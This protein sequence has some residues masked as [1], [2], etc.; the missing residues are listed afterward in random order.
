MAFGQGFAFGVKGGLSVGF[1]KWGIDGQGSQRDPLMAY[2][3]IAYI[4]S[5]PEDNA[6]AV[7]AQGGYHVRGGAVR[8]RTRTVR[9]IAGNLRDLPGRSDRYEFRNVSLA[10]GGKQKKDFGN[11][12]SKVYY[13][14]GLRGDY[15]INTNLFIYETFNNSF[16]PYYPVDGFVQ[17]F[18]YGVIVGGGFEFPIT[19][20]IGMLVEVSINPDFSKQ[21]RQ[22]PIPNVTNPYNSML[23]NLPS[24]ELSNTT[25]EITLGFRFLNK[26]EYID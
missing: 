26:I 1:Q 13:F 24:R 9:D 22:P 5:A 3:G 4:E 16:A 11:G 6:F 21:Y 8:T 14:M 10:F 25:L 12:D 7:F 19:D 15:T 23:V 2:H 17:K 18:N 20:L